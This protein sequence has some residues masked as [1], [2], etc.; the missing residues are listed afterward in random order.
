MRS[1][2]DALGER[3]RRALGRAGIVSGYRHSCR[4]CK[5]KGRE[6]VEEHPEN[7]RRDCP[8]CGMTLWA[9]PLPRPFRLHDTRHRTATLLVSDGVDLYAVAKI[10][11]TPIQK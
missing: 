1:A 9:K 4:R 5:S 6:H 3:L 2:E 10:C 11:A 8:A 7:E